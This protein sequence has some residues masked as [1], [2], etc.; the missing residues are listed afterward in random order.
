MQIVYTSTNYKNSVYRSV[1]SIVLGLVLVLWPQVALTYI[2]MLIGL[3]F[4]LIGL[5]SFIIAYRS[6]KDNSGKL[7]PFSGIGSMALGLLLLCMP[8]F[9]QA[10]F[11]FLLGFILVLAAVGQFISLAAARHFGHISP[12]SYVFPVLIFVAGLVV[13][14]KPFEISESVGMLFGIAAI[15][16][17]VT[18]LINQYNIRKLRRANEAKEQIM[19]MDSEPEIV[20]AE[21]EDVN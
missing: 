17:G 4:L 21:Y 1:I 19:K 15:F 13:I 20:D 16:Y 8:G 14:F 10:I 12:V 5:I 18:D 3:T 6:K 11:M 7:V 9:F 2:V